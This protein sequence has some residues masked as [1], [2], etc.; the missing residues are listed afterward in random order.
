VGNTHTLERSGNAGR[1][2][3]LRSHLLT[4]LGSLYG[5][6]QELYTQLLLSQEGGPGMRDRWQQALEQTYTEAIDQCKL[7][8]A[9]DPRNDRPADVRFWVA[10]NR[11]RSQAQELSPRKG[12]N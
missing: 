4:E 3:R 7:A 9:I 11:L 10:R 5:A 2:A 8:L 6:A 1:Y 12:E